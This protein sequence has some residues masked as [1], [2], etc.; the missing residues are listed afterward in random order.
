MDAK[1]IN[2]KKFSVIG[3]AR[4]GLA[5]TRLLKSLNGD[6]FVS[7][8]KPA[9]KMRQAVQELEK[10][11]ARYEFGGHTERVLD[12]DYMV[13]SPG[14]P[15]NV[16]VIRKAKDAGL[17]VVSEI[18]VASWFCRAPIIA[19]T[20]ANGKTTTT[21]L[22]GAIV[23]QAKY[24]CAIAGNIGLP[25]SDCVPG[26]DEHSVAV[27]EVSSFQLDNID[28]FKPKIAVLTNITPD[29]L[30][31]YSSFEDYIASKG[32]IFQ[33]QTETD[34]LV[35][36]DD[37]EI[38]QRLVQSAKS[39]KLP[40]SVNHQLQEGA[41]VEGGT[42][43]C[44]LGGV[45]EIVIGVNEIKIRGTHNLY[46][47]LA[48]TLAACAFGILPGGIIRVGTWHAMS[49]LQSFEGVA[50]RLEFVRELNGVKF[51]NDSKATN[52]NSVWY[53]LESFGE[54]IILIAGG[55]DK[56]N[57]YARLYDF[58]RQKVKA[59]VLI[60]EAAEKMN[61]EFHDKTNTFRASSM[62]EAVQRASNLAEAGDV[63][64]LSP[65]CASFDMFDNYEHRGEVFKRTVNAL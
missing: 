25:F 40:F 36:N 31:R 63:V 32:R 29:H 11:G 42:V 48:A 22:I 64:L 10:I 65:A 20:G 53:A 59:M 43:V 33:N 1:D 35:Y 30:D 18:E 57:D 19:I 9:E 45:K 6:V 26:L 13:I 23:Q 61:Y 28:T 62:E 50:H 27:V 12:A 17:K 3:C 24:P 38:V 16:Y 44:T 49:V 21:S 47:S 51:I 60:G 39:R 58:V 15:E 55:R 5:V 54:S 52:V 7:D 37:D 34:F 56:G 8:V 46:N 14:V 4:S 41:Y 2:G